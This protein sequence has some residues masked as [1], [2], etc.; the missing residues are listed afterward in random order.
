M[1]L[2]LY[3]AITHFGKDSDKPRMIHWYCPERLKPL[4][5]GRELIDD[6]HLC[7][8]EPIVLSNFEYK[9]YYDL[10][11]EEERKRLLTPLDPD[12]PDY[13]EGV[14]LS[15]E[16]I[17]IW[18][19]YRYSKD[20]LTRAINELF[21]EK[22]TEIL[23]QYLQEKYGFS[24]DAMEV[25]F[26]MSNF[27]LRGYCR[28]AWNSDEEPDYILHEDPDF[29]LPIPVEGSLEDV[30]VINVNITLEESGQLKFRF[31]DDT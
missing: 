22:E 17:E 1:Q 10:F 24:L 12:D 5:D 29:P 16:E 6:Y 27:C 28:E 4:A 21:T 19:N 15:K 2:K 3:W 25:D 18:Y 23:K 14:D 13:M 31:E 20:E 8:D 11:T 30:H 9:A 26:P 7:P